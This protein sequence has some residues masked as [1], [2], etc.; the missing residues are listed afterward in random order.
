MF[1][2]CPHFITRAVCGLGGLVSVC[3]GGRGAS[4]SEL[5]V[6]ADVSDRSRAVE[7]QGARWAVRV[8]EEGGD[9]GDGGHQHGADLGALVVAGQ[10]DD[11]VVLVPHVEGVVGERVHQRRVA[12]GRALRR[13]AVFLLLFIPGR[14]EHA[15]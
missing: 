7:H 5:P 13:A 2:V 14:A 8:R 6:A 15:L 4:Q 11:H 12:G 1:H 9:V 10:R 3:V